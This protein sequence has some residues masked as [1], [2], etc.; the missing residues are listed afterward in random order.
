M[1]GPKSEPPMP[2]LTLLYLRQYISLKEESR[3]EH[4]AAETKG[5][6]DKLVC[7]ANVEEETDLSTSKIMAND[8]TDEQNL[9][10]DC[11]HAICNCTVTAGEIY[12]SSYCE[13]APE[14]A[15]TACACGHPDCAGEQA[16][17]EES[18]DRPI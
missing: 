16:T 2:I 7:D 8:V 12:C 17:V 6:A 1:M 10:H 14:S 3:D 15:Y 11:A 13:N 5:D 18:P 9:L 4:R